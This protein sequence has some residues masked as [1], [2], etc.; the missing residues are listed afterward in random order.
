MLVRMWR[1]LNTF[2]LMVGLQAGITTLEINLEVA[3]KIANSFTED[4]LMPLL[5]LY[6]EDAPTCIKDT[7]FT[8]FIETLY[9]I[10]STGMNPD[11]PQLRNR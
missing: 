5:G 3:A 4:P 9:I 10:V 6:T 1:K 8:M 2:P 11:I 7:C